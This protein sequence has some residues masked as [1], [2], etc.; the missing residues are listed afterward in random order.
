MYTIEGSAVKGAYSPRLYTYPQWDPSL[1]GYRLQHFLYD[2]DRKTFTDVSALVTFNDKSAVYRP[3]SYGMLQSL[4]FN[5]NLR[6]V[7][8]T[9]ESMTFIQYTD[10]VLLKDLNG[11]GTRW[12]VT[13]VK[14][15]PQYSNLFATT[16]NNGA[17]TTFTVQNGFTTQSDWLNGLYWAVQPSYNSFNEEK[18]PAPT[19][20][21]LMHE[22]GR[23][24]RF[25]IV[26]WN[27]ANAVSI[28]LPLGKTMYLDWVNRASDGTELQLGTTGIVITA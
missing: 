18:A 24:W 2:L 25:P 21:D 4:I 16:I 1:I 10:I 15:K 27:L 11:I 23:K 26:S 22:D 28:S 20:F 13:P 5:L 7:S 9:Y 8:P 6:D 3:S 14:D 12:V 19:H 17:Q